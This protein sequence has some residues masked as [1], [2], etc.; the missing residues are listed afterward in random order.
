LTID[1]SNGTNYT[2]IVFKLLKQPLE[3]YL[4]SEPVVLGAD[5][6]IPMAFIDSNCVTILKACKNPQTFE[7]A[8]EICVHANKVANYKYGENKA[9]L[10]EQIGVLSINARTSPHEIQTTEFGNYLLSYNDTFVTSV[11]IRLLAHIP[12]IHKLMSEPSGNP[13]DVTSVFPDSYSYSTIKRRSSSIIHII[14]DL[15]SEYGT[16]GYSSRIKISE[17]TLE[18]I[19]ENDYQDD[20]SDFDDSIN[21]TREEMPPQYDDSESLID[22]GKIQSLENYPRIKSNVDCQS[23]RDKDCST[24][25]DVYDLKK[26]EF[27]ESVQE[28]STKENVVDWELTLKH[29]ILSKIKSFLNKFYKINNESKIAS[30]F[31]SLV[32]IVEDPS[33]EYITQTLAYLPFGYLVKYGRLNEQSV[34]EIEC[35]CFLS[36]LKIYEIN[37]DLLIYNLSSGFTLNDFYNLRE[38][39]V[40][41][42]GIVLQDVKKHLCIEEFFDRAAPEAT[43]EKY[44][45]ELKQ[46]YTSE[47]NLYYRLITEGTEMLDEDSFMRSMQI[48]SQS[49]LEYPIN[50]IDIK[51]VPLLKND[52]AEK[53]HDESIKEC[54]MSEIRAKTQFD[55]LSQMWDYCYEDW[56]DTINELLLFAY[57]LSPHRIIQ[58]DDS[59][60]LYAVSQAIVD[61]SN[62]FEDDDIQLEIDCLYESVISKTPEEL[63]IKVLNRVNS[64]MIYSYLNTDFIPL[65][66]NL[67]DDII[68]VTKICYNI[69]NK[70]GRKA[71]YKSRLGIGSSLDVFEKSDVKQIRE[72][73]DH[74]DSERCRQNRY[75]NKMR[76]DY[77]D[78]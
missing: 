63:Q 71:K 16:S 43:S 23:N 24:N 1:I 64:I 19:G 73:R 14:K 46:L 26:Y 68:C 50:G 67:Q 8:G 51:Y 17:N 41:K 52:D 58:T 72:H 5:P 30:M 21:D 55:D 15:E 11:M 25:E 74:T 12:V 44:L 27:V 40:V 69:D 10:M 13:I 38:S 59:D 22:S 37:M 48:I 39:Y 66:T 6:F 70:S 18:M 35:A 4:H 56:H 60:I 3:D 32:N 28:S 34:K 29:P 54:L 49:R 2:D 65:V 61:K 36:L 62:Y 42:Y 77:D 53:H 45:S 75:V 9:K 47:A 31:E 33:S 78:E 76:Y 7:S 57:V 20:C